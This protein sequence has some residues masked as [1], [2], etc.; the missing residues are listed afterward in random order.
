MPGQLI[1]GWDATNE[2]WVPIQV[3]ANGKLELASLEDAEISQAT[4]EDMK[5]LPHGYYSGGPS[6]LPLAVDSLGRLRVELSSLANLNDIGDVSVASP[7]DGYVVYWDAATSLWKCKA[8]STSKIQDADT[9]TKVDTEESADEDH[10]RMDVKGVEAFDLDDNGILTLAKQSGAM[11]QR[12]FPD[13][14]SIPDNTITLCEEDSEIFDVQGE[15]DSTTNYRFTATKAG[16][17]LYIGTI[18]WY[19]PVDQV[20]YHNRI[21]KNGSLL[22]QAV[23]AASGTAA[24]AFSCLGVA[25][26][27]ASDY[28][29]LRAW[30]VSGAAKNIIPVLAV[31]K[32]A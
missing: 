1:W 25:Q 15:F 27:A 5:H 7:T 23:M 21:H 28:L 20:G 9:D 17:Y 3:D 4:P 29:D 22:T 16:L 26:L 2:K 11:A 10:V 8:I 32:V 30:H 24:F 14:Q 19:S 13:Y 6:Y 31:A 12:D 18:T